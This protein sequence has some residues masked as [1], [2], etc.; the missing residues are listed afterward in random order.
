MDVVK[1]IR[2]VKSRPPL[3][4]RK[5]GSYHD[6][7]LTMV[8]WE[9]VAKQI[10]VDSE[11]VRSKWKSLRDTFRGELKKLNRALLKGSPTSAT[12]WEYFDEMV[13]VKDQIYSNRRSFESMLKTHPTAD[14]D[15]A[16]ICK[17]EVVEEDEELQESDSDQNSRPPPLKRDRREQDFDDDYN[18]LLS[19]L[20]QLRALPMTRN[21]FVRIKIQ[22]LLYNEIVSLQTYNTHS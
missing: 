3:W 9:D 16:D 17:A 12:N 8:L 21:L 4:D 14:L 19:L 5:D 10:G 15:P 18:F 6:R 7:G 20:P 13:F 2:S 22:E 11:S 1:L